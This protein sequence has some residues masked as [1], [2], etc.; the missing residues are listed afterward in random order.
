M[1]YVGKHARSPDEMPNEGILMR[2]RKHPRSRGAAREPGSA[3]R[4]AI[5]RANTT[6]IGGGDAGQRPAPD[7][8]Q[9][10]HSRADGADRWQEQ[11][12]EDDRRDSISEARSV[13]ESSYC[14]AQISR[15]MR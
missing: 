2:S 12:S 15:F 7:G 1:S 5:G 13:I 11:H 10:W 14:V 8:I 9:P 3:R 4:R 6:G